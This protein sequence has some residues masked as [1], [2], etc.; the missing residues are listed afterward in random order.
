MPLNFAIEFCNLNLK[1]WYSTIISNIKFPISIGK[2]KSRLFSDLISYNYDIDTVIG[3]IHLPSVVLDI[4]GIYDTVIFIDSIEITPEFRHSGV[5]SYI[6]KEFCNRY[7]GIPILLNAGYMDELEYNV[8]RDTGNRCVLERLE[9]FYTKN[10]FVN[11]NHIMGISSESISMINY[12][13][14]EIILW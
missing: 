11:V 8:F 1:G 12:N 7:T 14:K 13:G 6:L 9:R 10:G 3:G 5:G 4:I 2:I